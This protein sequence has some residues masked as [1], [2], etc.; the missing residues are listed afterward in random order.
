MASLRTGIRRAL[1][2]RGAPD[3]RLGR[4]GEFQQARYAA[5]VAGLQRGHGHRRVVACR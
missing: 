2:R 1:E 3:R 5:I 4:G